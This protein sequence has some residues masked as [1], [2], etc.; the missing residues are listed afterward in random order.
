MQLRPIVLTTIASGILSY[1]QFY[2]IFILMSMLNN[3]EE[4][5]IQARRS[6]KN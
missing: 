2:L 5:N 1:P 6:K 4:S 3:F